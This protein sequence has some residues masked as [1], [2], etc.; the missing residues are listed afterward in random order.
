MQGNRNSLLAARECRAAKKRIARM[1][2]MARICANGHTR[3]VRQLRKFW[4]KRTLAAS[5]ERAKTVE[6][7]VIIGQRNFSVTSVKRLSRLPDKFGSPGNF[8]LRYCLR[9]ERQ[10]AVGG[11]PAVK[12]LGK[13]LVPFRFIRPYDRLVFTDRIIDYHNIPAAGLLLDFERGKSL[14][15]DIDL[16]RNSPLLPEEQRYGELCKPEKQ[17]KSS[18]CHDADW[19][20][21]IEKFILL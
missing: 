14:G 4:I 15:S 2:G 13:R 1:G 9:D 12:K 10:E 20:Q 11:M 17:Y 7:A 19:D 5:S 18:F 21:V 3:T 6:K 8:T 16:A